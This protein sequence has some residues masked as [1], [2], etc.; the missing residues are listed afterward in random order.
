VESTLQP[1]VFIYDRATTGDRRAFSL[2]LLLCQRFA[3]AEGWAIG[4]WFADT[5]NDALSPD[6]RPGLERLLATMSRTSPGGR[7]CYLLVH[8]LGRLAHS[9]QTQAAWGHR[10]HIAG[11]TTTTAVSRSADQR[12]RL[13]APLPLLPG[14][15]RRP[16]A[17]VAVPP[18]P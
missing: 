6:R 4:G 7:T 12:G 10:V 8:D 9:P 16:L 15:S 14:R 18:T 2:R 3:Q 13:G 1:V 5:G 11:G 17:A